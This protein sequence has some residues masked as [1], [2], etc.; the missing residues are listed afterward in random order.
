MQGIRD[1]MGIKVDIAATMGVSLTGRR[2]DNNSRMTQMVFHYSKKK[3]PQGKLR[4]F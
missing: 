4:I 1:L 2:K 3:S